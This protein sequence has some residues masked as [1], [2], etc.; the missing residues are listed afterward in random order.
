IYYLDNLLCDHMIEDA[1]TTPRASL[2]TSSIIEKIAKADKKC[3]GEKRYSFGHLPWRDRAGTCYQ[4]VGGDRQQAAGARPIHDISSDSDEAVCARG[5]RSVGA[6]RTMMSALLR[7]MLFQYVQRKQ[8]SKG[9]TKIS[10][11]N[12]LRWRSQQRNLQPM[13]PSLQL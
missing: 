2:F 6:K 3:L 13:L 8:L 12:R 5:V 11:D 9:F 1:M 10:Q 4:N 7:R